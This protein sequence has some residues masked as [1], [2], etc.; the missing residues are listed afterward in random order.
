MQRITNWFGQFKWMR[1][2]PFII[3]IVSLIGIVILGALNQGGTED[4]TKR[5]FY[6]LLLL[7]IFFL[8][9]TTSYNKQIL[10]FKNRYGAR[11][12]ILM[13]L[14]IFLCYVLLFFYPQS[15]K[16]ITPLSIILICLIGIYSLFLVITVLGIKWNLPLLGMVLIF[17]VI[18]ATCTA[19][20][21]DFSHYDAT[22]TKEITNTPADR[23][24]LES[25]IQQWVLDRKQDMT[26]QKPGE[27]FPIIFV[28]AEGGGSRA[29]LW[30]FLVQSYLFDQNPDYFEKHL[31][32]MSGAS[33]GGG[34]NNM[35][36]TQAYELLENKTASPLKYLTPEDGFNYRASIVYQQDY[37]SS[38]VACLLGRDTF[39]S[40]TNLFTFQ[41]RGAILE[42]EW[43]T[44]FNAAFNR[45]DNPLGQSYLN[46]MPQ[47]GK[48]KYIRPL[49][50]TNTTEMQSG[51]RVVISPVDISKDIHNMGVFKDLIKTYPNK[52]AMIKRS[53]AMSMNARFP[54]LSPVA[55]IRELGQFGDAGY[56]NN[57]GG[58][59]TRRLEKALLKVITK[60]SSLIGKYEIKHL[61]ISNY[62]GV[63]KL[64][65]SSQ[66]VAP[67]LMI[68]NATFA[69]PEESEKTLTNVLNIQSK[70]TYIPQE[71]KS[72][73]SLISSETDNVEYIKP[74]I[75]LGRYLSHAAVRSLEARLDASEVKDSLDSLIPKN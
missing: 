1:S 6:S 34:G 9:I 35:F 55:R 36:Y 57:I 29:G 41:D 22:F 73:F 67:A 39:K 11:L 20:K 43:E 38:S 26:N 51:Q 25:Y 70:R 72:I 12:I 46:M 16:L 65:Y 68:A 31:F 64:S 52:K 74:I 19:N 30:S 60:D 24:D 23:L 50:I 58:D 45:Q 71:T 3:L 28:S 42:N 53:T 61:L 48:Y 21:E 8:M 44:R 62:E 56:Y 69:H 2:V 15:I 37:L 5:L 59:V 14:F 33:G 54:Y 66:L 75:P 4:D 32:S 7:A 63:N 49:L 13:T 27:K 10:K 47:T 18:L 17:S 40:I